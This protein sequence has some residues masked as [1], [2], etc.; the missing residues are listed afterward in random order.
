MVAP[1]ILTNASSVLAL[2]VDRTRIVAA[3]LASFE[4]G[5]AD[6]EVW[7]AQLALST[8]AGGSL[9]GAALLPGGARISCGFGGW[10][11]R[12]LL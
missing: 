12:V 1:A 9:S 5:S 6:S 2:V 3:P 8:C 7:A 11:D 4:P 10:F